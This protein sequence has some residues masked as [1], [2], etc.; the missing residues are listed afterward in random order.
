MKFQDI[1]RYLGSP[2]N[3]DNFPRIYQPILIAAIVL[4]VLIIA[5]YL[6]NQRRIKDH[7][8][9][10]ELNEWFLWIGVTT[11]VVILIASVF[12]WR[13]WQ[14]ILAVIAGLGSLLYLRFRYY[15]P[16][17]TAYEEELRRKRYFPQTRVTAPKRKKR[18]KVKRR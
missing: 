12:H 11:F 10:R 18:S 17:I 13:F 6:F 9:Y 15:A 2:F 4:I 7:K 5:V 8:I 14:V 3:P 16:K 1:P